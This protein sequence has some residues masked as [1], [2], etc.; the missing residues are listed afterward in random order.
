MLQ[1]VKTALPGVDAPDKAKSS[2]IAGGAPYAD[3]VLKALDSAI[4]EE[5]KSAKAKANERAKAEKKRETVRMCCG[6]PCCG[7]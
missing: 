6:G 2:E 3:G 5:K 4:V 1:K 7:N